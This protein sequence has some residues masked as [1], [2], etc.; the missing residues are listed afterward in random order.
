MH[1]ALVNQWY[2]PETGGGGVATHNYHFANACVQMGH[3][4]SV[5]ASR[6]TSNVPV[7]RTLNGVTVRRILTPDF[8][9][10]RRF[11]VVG[12][13]YRF[14]QA[15]YYSRQACNALAR[16]H[17][18]HPVDVV[19]F[20][21]VNAEGFFWQEGSGRRMV[22]RCH[23]PAWVLEQYY[24]REETP[25]DANF[26]G[27]A[28]KR[29]L[30]RANALTAPSQDMAEIIS[31]DCGIPV[32]RLNVI[33]NAV[34]TGRFVPA[35]TPPQSGRVTILWVGR[36]E[37][38]KGIEVLIEAIPLICQQVPNVRFVVIGGSRPRPQGGLYSDYM[39]VH[40]ADYVAAGQLEVR[41]FTPDADLLS[42]YHES[43]ICVVPSTLYES[44]SFTVAQAMACGL[45][46]VGTRIGGIPETLAGGR[47]GVLVSPGNVQEFSEAVIA[48]ATDSA[49]RAAI[50]KTA[51]EHAVSTFSSDMVARQIV[52]LYEQVLQS[53]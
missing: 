32:K 12:R 42:A 1:I 34:D 48:L 53:H 11:L 40:L 13:Q 19:E 47:C 23:T 29:T 35:P 20:A 7:E 4:V 46:V 21:E 5:I 45:P 2:P 36:L 26:L 31:Q 17:G 41:G 16:L 37:R 43:H 3:Q 44:F 27:W 38:A 49:Y 8:Y 18:E 14:V 50:G 22:I 9:R 25:F 15:L 24:T 39:K 51:R 10:F 33:P 28:E 52:G 6:P 30:Q